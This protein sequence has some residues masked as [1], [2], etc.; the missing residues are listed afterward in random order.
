[1]VVAKTPEGQAHADFIDTAAVMV[2]V[3]GRVLCQWGDTSAK[4]MMRSMRKSL[5]S[6]LYGIAVKDGRIRLDKTLAE[7]RID[8]TPPSLTP[9]EKRA[10]VRDLLMARSGVYHPAALETP[11][12]AL[13]RPPRGSHAAGSHW[14]YNNW[15]FNVLGTIFGQQTRG[16]IF[17]AFRAQI[18]EPLQMED[19]RVG[20]GGYQRGPESQHA[21]YPL[22]M[23]TRDLARFDLLYLRKGTW[24]MRNSFPKPGSRKARDP[25]PTRAPAG[26]ATRGGWRPTGRACPACT[27]RTVPSGPGARVDTTSSLC[28]LG[29]L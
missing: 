7:L 21:G 12:M 14:Y 23:S 25:A 5:L 1:L 4:F 26:M 13:T 27:C 28:P 10:T 17:D 20:D 8:D 18:A 16:K 22:R 11:D 9:S 15:D 24:A 19:F 29:I 3:D 6:A 2:I